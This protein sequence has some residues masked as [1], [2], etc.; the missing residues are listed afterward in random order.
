MTR[1]E[2]HGVFDLMQGI[3]GTR[4]TLTTVGTNEYAV[5]VSLVGM[6][7]RRLLALT[8]LLRGVPDAK[9]VVHD[10]GVLA[11]R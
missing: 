5:M 3:D 2:A 4:P 10:N 1:D 7:R 9:V 11:I 6:D 8:D